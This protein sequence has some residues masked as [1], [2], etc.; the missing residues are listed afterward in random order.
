MLQDGLFQIDR[1]GVRGHAG[2]T[3]LGGLGVG[4]LLALVVDPAV[5]LGLDLG[6]EGA[7]DGGEGGGGG[8]GVLG[9]QQGAGDLGLAGGDGG[10]EVIVVA[11][12]S[13]VY[14]RCQ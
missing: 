6:P 9:G 5:A 11:N 13:K 1:D 12:F 8:D 3:E 2:Q 7:E 14:Q 10:G 4:D